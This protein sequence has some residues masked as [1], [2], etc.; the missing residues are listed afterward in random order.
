MVRDPRGRRAVRLRPSLQRHYRTGAD[1][2]HRR[3]PGPPARLFD[4]HP[5]YFAEHQLS[6]GRPWALVPRRPPLRARRDRTAGLP[7]RRRLRDL[8]REQ[9]QRARA[10]LQRPYPKRPALGRRQA[11]RD[12][13]DERRLRHRRGRRRGTATT[14][15]QVKGL[16]AKVAAHQVKGLGGKVAAQRGGPERQHAQ[17]TTSSP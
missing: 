9:D 15:H 1:R 2:L 10:S 7:E 6:G 5:H 12:R 11:R 3:S 17:S 16:G 4:E 13:P 14:A 8:G